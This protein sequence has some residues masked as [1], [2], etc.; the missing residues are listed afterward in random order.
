MSEGAPAALKGSDT[1]LV[2]LERELEGL[3]V[4]Y[5]SLSRAWPKEPH[6]VARAKIGRQVEVCHDATCSTDSIS[7]DGRGVT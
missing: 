5:E 1:N 6:V 4:E 7:A 2:E 3:L